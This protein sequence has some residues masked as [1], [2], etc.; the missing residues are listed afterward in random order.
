MQDVRQAMIQ[1]FLSGNGELRAAVHAFGVIYIRTVWQI[2]N[3][4]ENPTKIL[5]HAKNHQ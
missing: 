1:Y 4:K 5:S 2:T 3:S